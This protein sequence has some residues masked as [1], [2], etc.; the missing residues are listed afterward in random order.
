MEERLNDFFNDMY[1]R[2]L[3]ENTISAYKA[4]LNKYFS[5]YNELT[6]SN[7]I[8]WKKTMVEKEKTRSVNARIIAMNQFLKFIGRHDLCL[9]KIKEQT[10]TSVENVISYDDFNKLLNGLK[11]DGRIK[12]YL[13]CLFLGKTGARVSELIQFK[14]SDLKQGFAEMH[15]KGKIRRI[16]FCKSLLEDEH[17]KYF[18]DKKDDDFIFD[19]RFGEQITKRGIAQLLQN[20]A[21]IYGIDRKVMH[22]HSFRHF[23]AIEF[24][25]RDK[26]IALLADLLGHSSINTTMIYTRLNQSQQVER[27]NSAMNF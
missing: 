24:L 20:S 15:T 6:K 17:L 3:S 26:D 10:R 5:K 27:L 11:N 13:I 8:E 14:K 12:A 9:R 19:S 2:E 25:K 16:Y 23:F 7:L 18:E 22:P 1:E 4:G 21:R